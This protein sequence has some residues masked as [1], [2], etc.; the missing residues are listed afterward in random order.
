MLVLDTDHISLLV[1]E[2]NSE[3]GRRL[4]ERL[5]RYPASQIHSS[6][7]TYEEQTRGW[8]TFIA[9]AKTVTAEVDAYRKLE[10]HLAN[11]KRIKLLGFTAN[12]AVEFQRL[13]KL[14]IRIGTMDLKIAAI[15]MVHGATVLTRNRRDFEQV[16]GLN[17]EDWCR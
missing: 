11:Y 13:R 1:E 9:R 3:V 7:V 10:R 4:K 6:I 2:G 16:P 5:A 12:A 15:A 14:G 17:I 8:L